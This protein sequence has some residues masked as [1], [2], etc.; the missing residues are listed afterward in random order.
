MMY[1]KTLKMKQRRQKTT[2]SIKNTLLKNITFDAMIFHNIIF[3]VKKVP[4]GAATGAV[5]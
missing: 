3:G 1:K 2:M 5:L 4:L